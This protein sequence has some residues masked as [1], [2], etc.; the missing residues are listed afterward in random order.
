MQVLKDAAVYIE[1]C[2]AESN[3]NNNDD[4]KLR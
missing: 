1:I 3:N 2:F 4:K